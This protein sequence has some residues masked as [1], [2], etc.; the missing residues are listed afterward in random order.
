MN[1]IEN[2]YNLR[3]DFGIRLAASLMDG[4]IICVLSFILIMFGLASLFTGLAISSQYS[5]NGFASGAFIGG[6]I[7]TMIAMIGITYLVI[8]LYGLIEAFTG[9]SPG[10]RMLG[11]QIAYE[12]GTQGNVNL[13]FKRWVIKNIGS[14]LSLFS[15]LK[16]IGYI[17]NFIIFIACFAV[18]GEKRQALHDMF[19]K[20][21]VFKK[22]DIIIIEKTTFE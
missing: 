9:A 6:G 14:F 22:K 4:F 18:L 17:Y 3:C 8:L 5:T 7:G 16:F 15:Y 12:N 11:V 20:T 19:A 21:A 10:K 1:H 13:Y 2:N